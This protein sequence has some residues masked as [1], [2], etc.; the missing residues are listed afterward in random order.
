MAKVVAIGGVFFKSK[1]P[2]RLRS[3]YREG[4]GIECEPWGGKPF[5]HDKRDSPGVGYTVWSPF[6]E[7]TEYFAPSE[8]PYMI[9]M[10]VDDLDG[11]LER[12]REAGA[13]VLDRREEGEN[14][15]FGYVVDP[16]GNLLELW[17]QANPDPYAPES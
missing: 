8:K 11:V 1:D 5:V 10:R 16:E 7:E 4:L 3:W 15:R 6:P 9:N 13:K 2:D 14:G 17:Q 12:L